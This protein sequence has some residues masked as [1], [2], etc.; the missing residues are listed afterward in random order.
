MTDRARPET[1]LHERL[2]EL[3]GRLAHLQAS[4]NPA[5]SEEFVRLYQ[6]RRDILKKLEPRTT[7]VSG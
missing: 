5:D 1:R 7:R 6:E 2:A 4:N 3:N